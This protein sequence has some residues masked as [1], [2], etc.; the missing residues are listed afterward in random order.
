MTFDLVN[1]PLSKGVT[2]LEASA[3]TGK[4]FALAGI[5]LR[6][7]LEEKVPASDI[8]VV[9]FTEAATAELRDR[10]RRRL[11][12][13]LAVLEGKPSQDPLLVALKERVQARHDAAVRSLRNAL[14]IFDLVS[15]YT[16]HG[17]CQRT[18]QDSAFESGILF[19]VELVADQDDL[20]RETAADYC[21]N[22]LHQCDEVL[23]GAAI[24]TKLNPEALSRML[25]QF[26]TYPELQLLP[27][28]PPRP[29]EIITRE[30]RE[31]FA[32]FASAWQAMANDRPAL[33]NYFNPAKK[34]VTGEY[35]KHDLLEE[36][37]DQLDSCLDV[38]TLSS[39]LW[40]GIEFFSK[41]AIEAKK[42]KGK[43]MP[44]PP[45]PLFDQC[46]ALTDLAREHAV[47]HRVVFLQSAGRMLG[48]RKQQAKQQSYDDLITR[49]A[50]ALDSA[51]GPALAQTVRRKYRVA[52]ID[53]SQDT[54][55]LQWKIFQRVFAASQD[56]WLYL[57]G[58]P[59]Q[60]I[61]GFRGADVNTYLQAAATANQEYSLDTNWR[62]ES[63]LVNSVNA[64]FSSAGKTAAFLEENIL[65]EKVKPGPKAD[66]SPLLF[67][68]D[69]HRP[70]PFQVWC[71]E[72]ESGTVTSKQAKRQLPTAVAAEVSRLLNAKVRLG[73]NATLR[74]RD[75]A[76]L[77]ESHK[78]A[79]WTQ[80]ALHE[81]H[82]P[83]VEQA[84]E[85]V[86]ESGEAR[87]VQWILA[88][89]LAPGREAAVKSALTTDALGVS[90][91]KLQA[92]V[93]NES[94]W[95]ARLQSF[96]RYRDL[97]EEDGFFFMFSQL[98]REEEVIE[99]LLRFPDAERRITNLLHVAE[100]LETACKAEHLG[101]S[102]LVQWLE[103]RRMSEE[104]PPD[105]YQLRLESDEDA[106]QI[107]TIH[108]AKGL[109]YPVVFCPFVTKDAKP[110]SI[111]VN[112]QKVLDV[113]L[114]H[115]PGSKRLT[116]D[117][118]AEPEET[119]AQLAAKE[120]LAEKVRLL[121]VAL[122]RAC[123]R[124]YLVSARYARNKSTALA[125]LLR[126]Q[127]G[128][129][130]EQ[131]DPVTVLDKE[132]VVPSGWKSRWNDIASASA[133]P[134][135]GK[136]GI[137]VDDLPLEPGEPW[138][139]EQPASGGLTPKI[140]VREIRPSWFLSS[141]TQLSSH[142]SLRHALA[143]E[144][145]HPDHDEAAAGTLSVGTEDEATEPLTGIFALP[146]SAR[147][148]DC[149][150]KIIE[151]FDFA[152]AD[153]ATAKS[154]VRQQ[155]EAYDLYDEERARA[156][157]GM[158]ERLRHTPLD[159]ANPNL[160]LSAVSSAE[161]LTEMEFH[162]PTGHLDGARLLDLIRSPN[163][164]SAP[165]SSRAAVPVSRIQ[166]F[167][168][169]FIDLV[170]RFEGR[171]HVVDWKSNLLGTK[172]EAYTRE[173]MTRAVEESCYDLQ[174]HIYVV[175]LDKYLRKRV[176]GYEFETHFGGVHYVFLRGLAPGRPDLG[177]YHDRPSAQKIECLSSVL[178]TFEEVK[179]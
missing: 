118:N 168:K 85:S 76:V 112:R 51:S 40:Q 114:Y 67:P 39:Q 9:T 30:L 44:P 144:T 2:R 128:E 1:T 35:A 173:A 23:V 24:H 117:L 167:L 84:M 141:F 93:A 57:I 91:D 120:Q 48:E 54:D 8:L 148:G 43:E 124:C 42:G 132:S 100:L 162:F 104:A 164:S 111:K 92:L 157:I 176:P 151:R 75:I 31:A 108:R 143:S 61:Y 89:I 129:M 101:P 179:S 152:D 137:A 56:H 105:A 80:A 122:T 41:S 145:D 131:V 130:G 107:V 22:Q 169:G 37:M 29:I 60:A 68:A 96:A 71:W 73:E 115:D 82:I 165:A 174:Y 109:Q 106:V 126:S 14:E 123:N 136:P 4:T 94:S 140:C 133:D 66:E 87:E 159:P 142:L 55:P 134:A 16:I 26:L 53:E 21:R 163:P 166:A 103:E 74:P 18:L 20:I 86:L 113:V 69:D 6:L 150:H 175:A 171:Y 98:V 170:F 90:C 10:I 110:R 155:L 127:G 59:K 102:R 158:L 172:V 38:A 33:V 46:Q 63:A 5:F 161:R 19:D 58:D 97:W 177:V 135:G 62:S 79:R 81:L 32:A 3:G 83:S 64:L 27:A 160:I 50:A 125:W 65:F 149:L 178:G 36:Y 52:L 77:V 25:K 28:A 154:L 49:L 45:T 119:H 147:T 12:E 15:I 116:W 17:F 138:Q 156:V 99:N 146:A 88:A 70:P 7:L 72:S 121:Y 34:W 47:A 95:Q 139:P 11:S 153:E 78:Q 13:A